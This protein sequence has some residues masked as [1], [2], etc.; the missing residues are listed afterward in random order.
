[1]VNKKGIL[2]ITKVNLLI[3]FAV[4]LSSLTF[5]CKQVSAE[6]NVTYWDSK[7]IKIVTTT[8]KEFLRKYGFYNKKAFY[9]GYNNKRELAV[10]LYFNTKTKK[11]CGISYVNDYAYG[12]EIDSDT[13]ITQK[14]FT[15][16]KYTL[17][18]EHISNESDLYSDVTNYKEKKNY[19]VINKKKRLINFTSTGTYEGEK[20][21]LKV[22][23]FSYKKDG[24]LISKNVE[25]NSMIYGTT[26][27]TTTYYYDKSERLYYSD[28]YLSHGNLEQF[29]IYSGNS[30]T[31]SY[32]LRADHN[33]GMVDSYLIKITK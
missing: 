5:Y 6:T 4:L 3:L 26:E 1:M 2:K 19:K 7:Q 9:K 12:F 22:I 20:V 8:E 21:E 16:K 14:G 17:I 15:H 24:K 31:P 23:D 10:E 28:S 32:I 25:L 18:P 29:Y 11:G 27:S 33:L 30:K 13:Y